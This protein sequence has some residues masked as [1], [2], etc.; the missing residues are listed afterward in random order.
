MCPKTPYS[1][2][3]DGEESKSQTATLYQMIKEETKNQINKMLD[4]LKHNITK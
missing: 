2:K 4:E 1:P 3:I